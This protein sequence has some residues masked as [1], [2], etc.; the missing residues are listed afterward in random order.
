M[1]GLTNCRCA[2]LRDSGRGSH[3][4]DAI[5]KL[6]HGEPSAT[7]QPQNHWSFP[8]TDRQTLQLLFAHAVRTVHG[9]IG[10]VLPPELWELV[11]TKMSRGWFMRL[12]SET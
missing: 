5:V 8:Q 3:L 9:S 7:W 2:A 6:L 4:P 11:F 1:Q 10:A 12:P